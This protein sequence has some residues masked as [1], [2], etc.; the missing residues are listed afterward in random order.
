MKE[1]MKTP[2]IFDGRNLYDGRK[3]GALGIEHFG[4]GK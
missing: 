1:L 3:L 4:V 2:A